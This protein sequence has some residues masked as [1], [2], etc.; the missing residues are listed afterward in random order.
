VS[1]D[2]TLPDPPPCVRVGHRMVY[3]S[4][5]GQTFLFG[6]GQPNQLNDVWLFTGTTRHWERWTPGATLPHFRCCVGLAFDA[7]SGVGKILMYGGAHDAA[8]QAY[9]DTWSWDP[10]AG[11]V[12]LI[13]PCVQP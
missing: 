12:C 7:T 9:A 10:T 3:D 4:V 11:W 1:W 8:P 13:T 2:C 5:R 6:A